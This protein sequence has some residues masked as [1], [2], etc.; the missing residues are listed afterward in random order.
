FSRID[1]WS[2]EEKLI[3]DQAL[4]EWIIVNLQSFSV[5]TN[6][7]FIKLINTLDPRYILP[8]RTSLKEKVT[9]YFEGMRKIVKLDLEKI[10]GKVSLT[11][12]MWTSTLNNNSFLE[13]TIHYINKEWQL[14]HFLLDII[15]FNERHTANNI[16]DA[17]LS[18]LTEFSLKEK[19]L[20]IT[21]DNATTML[22]VGRLI[23]ESLEYDIVNS[24]FENYRYAA[25]MGLR[26]LKRG[27][28]MILL[29]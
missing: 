23:A 7:Q 16:T 6:P 9:E 5:V 27:K 22:A 10:P 14:K 28:S 3:R 29:F 4:V 19:V 26:Q 13:L 25:H 24:T 1:P 17:I 21:T 15:S 18:V 2:H 11:C 12:D 8:G 20:G